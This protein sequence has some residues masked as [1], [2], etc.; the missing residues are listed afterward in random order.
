MVAALQTMIGRTTQ[1]SVLTNFLYFIFFKHVSYKIKK[2]TESLNIKSEYNLKLWYNNY[3][4]KQHEH[5]I[6]LADKKQCTKCKNFK[7][8]SDFHKFAKSPDGYKHFCK[9][10][11]KEYDMA[12]NDPKRVMPRKIEGSKIHCRNCKK[13]LDQSKFRMKPIANKPYFLKNHC[14]ECRIE[15]QHRKT[16]KKHNMTLEKYLEIKKKQG[17]GCK[18]CGNHE[19][20]YRTRLSVDHDHACCPGE[21]SCGKCFRGLLCHSC[22]MALGSVKDDINILQKMIEYLK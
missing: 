17:D 14:E 12:E 13:Y 10:C 21:P 8:F 1:S 9:S 4:R 15:L 16:L 19:S 3:M 11:V 2:I 22:N 5:P 18:I 7:V 6:V 20:G